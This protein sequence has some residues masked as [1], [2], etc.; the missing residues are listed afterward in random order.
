MEGVEFD[1]DHYDVSRRLLAPLTGAAKHVH[2][3]HGDVTNDTTI[4]EVRA[5]APRRGLDHL[6]LLSMG[7][8]IGGPEVIT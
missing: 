7:K 8:H 3:T 2:I 4:Q 1:V 5:R 6:L